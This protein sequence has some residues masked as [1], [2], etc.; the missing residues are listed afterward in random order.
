MLLLCHPSHKSVV[1]NIYMHH[2]YICIMY[3]FMYVY[4]YISVYIYIVYLYICI[5][6]YIIDV[7]ADMTLICLVF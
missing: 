4:I 6:Q 2:M 1:R 5:L 7:K 3:I